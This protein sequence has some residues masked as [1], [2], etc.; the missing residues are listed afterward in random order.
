MGA[1][2]AH[3]PRGTRAIAIVAA[4]VSLVDGS[5]FRRRLRWHS[6]HRFATADSG[7]DHDR[8][9]ACEHDIDHDPA[10]DDDY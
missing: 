9:A 5:V 8:A 2:T 10:G 3:R 6:R 1:L 7:Y 4:T